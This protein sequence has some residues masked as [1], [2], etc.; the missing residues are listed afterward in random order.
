MEKY[1]T[2]VIQSSHS[3][4]DFRNIPEVRN[5]LKDKILHETLSHPRAFVHDIEEEIDK[6][7]DYV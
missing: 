1:L 4:N 7:L 5:K 6:V 2:F 3:I